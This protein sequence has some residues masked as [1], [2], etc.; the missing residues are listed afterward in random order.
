MREY[1]KK[2][3]EQIMSQPQDYVEDARNFF[4]KVNRSRAI[5][6]GKVVKTSMQA[7]FYGEKDRRTFEEIGKTIMSIGNKVAKEYEKNPEFRKLYGFSPLLEQLI[8]KNPGYSM[9][10]PMARYDI[11]YEDPENFMFCELNTDGSSAMNEDNVLGK[12]FI[13][14]K[15]YR[16]FVGQNKAVHHD[17]IEDWVLKSTAF[18]E[19]LK[20]HRPNIAIVDFLESGTPAEFEAFQDSYRK[21]GY[22]TVIADPKELDF[23]GKHL[24]YKDDVIHMIYRRLVTGEMMGDIERAKPLI[25]A[26]LADKAML[27]GG[28]RSQ[29]M[30]TKRIFAILHHPFCRKFLSGEELDFIEKHIPET[31]ILD[32]TKLKEYSKKKDDWVIK[33][34]DGYGG[35]GIFF[36]EDLS[37]E[38]F[39]RILEDASEHTLLQ[40]RIRPK[41]MPVINFRENHFTVEPMVWIIGIFYYLEKFQGIYTRGDKE[42]IIAQDAY[43]LPH[44]EW[45]GGNE[46]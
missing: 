38:D 43:S 4:Q 7:V 21:K 23:D 9:T 35:K 8:L 20:G 27:L 26:Y 11:F 41:P 31:Q 2:Y 32:K 10:V 37:S 16:D 30:H 19:K 13:Q 3:V 33:A 39:I 6:H 46:K 34:E 28:F 45:M 24:Y 29:L 36:G 18:F 5:Y 12:L 17:L 15:A 40:K 14:T 22:F 44:I 25:D 42:G 1:A